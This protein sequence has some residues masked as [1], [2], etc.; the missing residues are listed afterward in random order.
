MQIKI[1]DED[2]ERR[3]DR[4]M[5]SMGAETPEEAIRRLL[6]AQEEQDRWLL[7]NRELIE[8]KIQRGLDQFERGEGIDEEDLDDYL[9]ELKSKLE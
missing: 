1:Q 6:E 5:Q 8:A 3:L 4:Q 9:R 7:E 2:L